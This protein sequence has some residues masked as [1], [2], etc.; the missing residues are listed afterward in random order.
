MEEDG[1]RVSELWARVPLC[2]GDIWGKGPVVPLTGVPCGNGEGASG[3]EKGLLLVQHQI[4]GP[5]VYTC[6]VPVPWPVSAL[7]KCSGAAEQG[8]LALLQESEMEGPRSVL[9]K[10]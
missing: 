4:R 9:F 5:G 10:S 1:P 8:G 7:T 2:G 3:Q 6:C